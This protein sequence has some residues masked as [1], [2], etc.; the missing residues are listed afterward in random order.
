MQKAIG[1]S[2]VFP[3]LKSIQLLPQLGTGWHINSMASASNPSPRVDCMGN[4]P[5]PDL[6][7]IVKRE[8][9]QFILGRK[10]NSNELLRN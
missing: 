10:I 2:F 5:H 9:G 4:I 6:L 8:R 7:S 3:P 1:G